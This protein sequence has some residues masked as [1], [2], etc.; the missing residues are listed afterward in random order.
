MT[1]KAQAI[2]NA[3]PRGKP[4]K[5]TDGQGLCLLV[6]P[7]GSRWWRLRYRFQGKE[8][9]LS[10]GTFPA[11]SL[12][13]ARDK[14]NELRRQ[15]A[16]GMDPGLQ[17]RAR[18]QADANGFEAVAREWHAKQA[19]T[20]TPEH[21]ERV[22]RRFQNDVFPWI[23]ARPI[24]DLTAPDLL[25]VLRRIESRSVLDTAHRALQTCSAVFRY[26]VATGRAPRDP[27]ADLRGAL[28]PVRGKHHA[29][30]TD[31]KAVGELLRALEGYQ[32]S[33]VTRCALRL[34]P[35]VFVRPGELRRAEWAEID[36]EAGEWRIPAEKMK[37]RVEHIVPLSRQAVAV[38]REVQP[39]T[40]GG[41]YVF[42]SL[43][44]AERPM[45]EN[46][47]LAALR[48]MGYGKDQ[49]TGHGFRSLASTLLNEQGWSRD[50][51]ERQL[52]HAERDATRAAY[53]RAEYLSERRRMM[54]A[55]ADYLDGLAAGGQ[56]V[57]IHGVNASGGW[58]KR[59]LP[60][61]G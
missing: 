21:A 43:R 33:L 13:D 3:K 36:L 11:V 52:A 14:R 18:Q 59:A 49:M 48:R 56:V 5:L 27:C 22:M 32:G 58:H 8:R 24:A 44:T 54:Q 23:G 16:A 19:H 29:A 61:R 57:P 53:N 17:R 47:V 1:L 50:A 6:Q 30:I 9:M 20:W 28:P 42:P 25:A 26:A 51:I 60:T 55:W 12:K 46:A 35:L 31:P 15:V 34:A 45:S 2:Q 38:L 40:G 37:A 4:Y 10:L 7:N 39:L 41:R